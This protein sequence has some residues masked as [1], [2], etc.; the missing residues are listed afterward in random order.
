MFKQVLFEQR[1]EEKKGGREIK[2]RYTQ[3]SVHY[4]FFLTILFI[5]TENLTNKNFFFIFLPLSC[6]ERAKYTPGIIEGAV[7]IDAVYVI[8][9]EFLVI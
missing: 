4:T 7:L 3:P 8:R 2:L 6:E 5:N 1:N 9:K